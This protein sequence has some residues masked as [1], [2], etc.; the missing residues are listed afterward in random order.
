MLALIGNSELNQF[1]ITS[2]TEGRAYLENPPIKFFTKVK[3]MRTSENHSRNSP[4]TEFSYN[5]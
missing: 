1:T 4:I 3:H 5:N 2:Q